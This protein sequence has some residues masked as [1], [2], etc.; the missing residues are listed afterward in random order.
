MDELRNESKCDYAILIS[1]YERE[2][3]SNNYE[4]SDLCHEYP[5]MFA[6]RPNFFTTMLSILKSISLDNKGPKKDNPTITE[7]TESENFDVIPSI[8]DTLQKGLMVIINLASIDSKERQR[9]SDILTGATFSIKG[10]LKNI[11]DLTYVCTPANHIIKNS[12]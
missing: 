7:Y 10:S 6:I 4:I 2:G 8:I 1:D 5:K 11:E 3:E 12:N 9:F